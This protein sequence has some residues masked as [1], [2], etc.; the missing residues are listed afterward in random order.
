MSNTRLDLQIQRQREK[1]EEPVLHK[2]LEEILCRLT[3]LE[4]RLSRLE[5]RVE[6]RK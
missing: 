6:S 2:D 1:M 3:S 4:E 5:G